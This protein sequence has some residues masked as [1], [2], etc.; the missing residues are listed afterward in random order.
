[1]P[2]RFIVLTVL[3]ALAAHSH[4]QTT[5]PRPIRVLVGYPPGG[6]TDVTARVVMDAA[7]KALGQAIIIDNRPGAAGA[8]ANE[9]LVRSAPDGQTLIVAPDSSL[10]QPVLKLP[11]AERSRV[12]EQ[13]ITLLLAEAA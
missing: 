7:A 11:Q 2:V 5:P 4:A 13:I 9:A 1:M 3:F 12:V 8:I 10:Y 6:S